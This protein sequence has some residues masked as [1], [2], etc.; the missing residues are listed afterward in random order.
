MHHTLVRIDQETAFY[1]LVSEGS[2]NDY[3]VISSEG[4]RRMMA[5]PEVIGYDCCK[6]VREP[7]TAALKALEPNLRKATILTILRGGLNYPLEECCHDCGIRIDNINFLSCE[8]VIRNHVIEGLEI[9]YDKLHPEKDATLMIGD[10]LASGDT[11]RK[12]LHH[13]IDEFDRAGGSLRKIIFFTIGGTKAFPLMEGLT[14]EIRQKWPAFEGFECIFFEG[15]FTVYE[16]KGVTGVNVPM[17]DFGWKGGCISPEFREYILDYKHAP[18]LL[19]KC[20]IYDGGARRYE[21]GDHFEEVIGYW[22]D[23][24]AAAPSADMDEFLA[25][26]A[27]YPLGTTYPE[28]LAIN[29]YPAEWNLE[30][31]YRKEQRYLAELRGQSLA[32]ICEAR[33][34]QLL[35]LIKQ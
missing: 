33:L 13:T 25:E 27:G 23:L 18:A 21:I 9:K 11:I 22:K 28:W 5:S 30:P 29:G 20:I 15:A 24:L 1:K 16:D 14:A 10:I 8:R 17:I 7:M 3:Y 32:A 19:E 2:L 12:C 26:K 6:A 4:T 31:L 35:N 34:T